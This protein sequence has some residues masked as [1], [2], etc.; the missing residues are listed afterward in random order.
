[1]P[2]KIA[3]RSDQS[4]S[5]YKRYLH[6]LAGSRFSS[7]AATGEFWIASGFFN[8]YQVI[9][10][11]HG[12]P[13]R[14]LPD[15]INFGCGV[16]K[17]FAS[18]AHVTPGH[19]GYALGLRSFVAAVKAKSTVTVY[20]SKLTSW[21]AKVAMRLI[22][23]KPIAALIGSSNAT[24]PAYSETST[25][26]W[27]YECDVLMWLDKPEY[28]SVLAPPIGIEADGETSELI[29]QVVGSSSDIVGAPAIPTATL[30]GQLIALRRRLERLTDKIT[31]API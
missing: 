27:H 14:T 11:T 17:V 24:V 6:L 8:G 29:G 25:G 13:A 4:K 28:N 30:E 21:H 12:S 1:V 23:D 19:R 18:R 15:A 22:D 16:T 7:S 31:L 20:E 26:P 9:K 2:F 10:E 3:L 5:F